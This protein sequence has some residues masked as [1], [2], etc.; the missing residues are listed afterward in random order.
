MART[1][2]AW[3]CAGSWAPLGADEREALIQ[4]LDR[5][6]ILPRPHQL[7]EVV[8]AL[9]AGRIPRLA[10]RGCGLAGH[11][12]ALID[13]AVVDVGGRQVGEEHGPLLHGHAIQH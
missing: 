3:G 12:A 9:R 10:Q 5:R 1:L 8:Q 2:N 11:L 7:T 13:L 4:L 6:P